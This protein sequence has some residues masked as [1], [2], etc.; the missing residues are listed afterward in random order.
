MSGPIHMA[1]GP[2]WV[3][4]RL[5]QAAEEGRATEMPAAMNIR[6]EAAKID[7]VIQ[8]AAWSWPSP[9]L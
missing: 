1:A 2:S 6:T 7:P 4:K 3:P 9:A 8:T 5:G